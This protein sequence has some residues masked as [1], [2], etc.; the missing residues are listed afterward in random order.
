MSIPARESP[1]SRG[2]GLTL[3]GYCDTK[4]RW[5]VSHLHYPN[6]A[7][8]RDGRRKDIKPICGTKNDREREK[9]TARTKKHEKNCL[10]TAEIM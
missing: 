9:V 6:R 7:A 1:S 5:N 4:C 8:Y 10:P 2:F 3:S